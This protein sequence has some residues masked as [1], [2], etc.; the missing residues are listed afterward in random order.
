MWQMLLISSRVSK[1]KYQYQAEVGDVKK[2]VGIGRLESVGR[3]LQLRPLRDIFNEWKAYVTESAKD[4]FKGHLSTK[5]KDAE[6]LAVGI[7]F[8]CAMAYINILEKKQIMVNVFSF[9]SAWKDEVVLKK[10]EL[11]RGDV[12]IAVLKKLFQRAFEG[13]VRGDVY[14][15][16][17]IWKDVIQKKLQQ[18][19]DVVHENKEVSA[20]KVQHLT[21]SQKRS[22]MTRLAWIGKHLLNDGARHCWSIW[23]SCVRDGTEEKHKTKIAET[24]LQGKR[25]AA[26]LWLLKPDKKGLTDLFYHWKQCVMIIQNTRSNEAAATDVA[27]LLHDK[28]MLMRMTRELGLQLVQATRD[29]SEMDDQGEIL[30]AAVEDKKL[31]C[32][33]LMY[34]EDLLLTTREQV[35]AYRAQAKGNTAS[36]FRLLFG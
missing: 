18:E 32:E 3:E 9:F 10:E 17:A 11:L 33:E 13:W 7:R 23:L 30:H 27:R 31:L 34:C 25:E 5:D 26:L 1:V 14:Y 28:S 29:M 12:N 6:I 21:G 35:V 36:P 16:M 15:A 24:A 22:A 20:R 4:R 19:K 8:Q 2:M